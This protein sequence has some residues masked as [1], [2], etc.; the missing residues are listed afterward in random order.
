[1]ARSTCV[2]PSSSIYALYLYAHLVVPCDRCWK[3]PKMRW[4]TLLSL[5]L[6]ILTSS[7]RPWSR[8]PL[9]RGCPGR[10]CMGLNDPPLEL[11]EENASL[12]LEEVRRELGTIFGYDQRSRDVGI[13]GQIELVEVDGPT[14]VVKLTG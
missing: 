5:A 4:A 2:I 1:M 3:T 6:P 7:F 11:C 9:S 10:V 14:L 13:T 8:I 12:V